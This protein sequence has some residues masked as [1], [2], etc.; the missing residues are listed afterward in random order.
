MQALLRGW[1][2]PET[3]EKFNECMWADTITKPLAEVSHRQAAA[4]AATA[5][6]PCACARIACILECNYVFSLVHRVSAPLC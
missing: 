5:L 6:A 2:Y 1:K 4:A 3:A